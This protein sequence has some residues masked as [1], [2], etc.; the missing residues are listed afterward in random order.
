M[1]NF[2]CFISRVMIMIGW[3]NYHCGTRRFGDVVVIIVI[4]FDELVQDGV[5]GGKNK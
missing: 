4:L 1:M 2:F 3:R 5:F